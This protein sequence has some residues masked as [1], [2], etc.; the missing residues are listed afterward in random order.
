MFIVPISSTITPVESLFGNTAAAENAGNDDTPKFSDVFKEIFQ[1]VQDTQ[2]TVQEDVVKLTL[3]EID[4]L[5]TIY[6][7]MTKASVA[8]DT[9]VAVKDAAVNAYNSILQITM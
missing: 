9:F 7:N 2:T 1:E 3:G 5:H 4:D 6:N 8:I